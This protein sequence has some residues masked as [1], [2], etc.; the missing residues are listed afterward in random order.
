VGPKLA[1]TLAEHQ[2]AV[3]HEPVLVADVA[4]IFGKTVGT[5]EA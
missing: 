2:V 4:A 3:G 1:T 5:L